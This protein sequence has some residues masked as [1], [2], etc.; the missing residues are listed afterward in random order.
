MKKCLLILLTAAIFIL[1]FISTAAAI[2]VKPITREEFEQYVKKPSPLQVTRDDP[3]IKAQV[4]D[5]PAPDFSNPSLTFTI[6]AQKVRMKDPEGNLLS[7]QVIPLDNTTAAVHD[8]VALLIETKEDW[9]TGLPQNGSI[10]LTAGCYTLSGGVD[11]SAG[12]RVLVVETD[13]TMN[14]F[15]SGGV[16]NGVLAVGDDSLEVCTCIAALK[17]LETKK[18]YDVDKTIDLGA[19]GHITLHGTVYLDY[20]FDAG[21]TGYGPYLFINKFSLEP[22]MDHIEVDLKKEFHVVDTPIIKF[23]IPIIDGVFGIDISPCFFIDVGVEGDVS[24][25]LKAGTGFSAKFRVIFGVLDI[26]DVDGYV[27]DPDASLIACNIGGEVYAGLEFGPSLSILSGVIQVGVTCRVGPVVEGFFMKTPFYPD[28]LNLYRYHA[29]RSL[30]CAQGDVHLRVGPASVI[31]RVVGSETTLYNIMNPIDYDPFA[32][33][34]YSHTYGEGSVEHQCPHH[35]YLV[36]TYVVDQNGGILPDALAGYQPYEDRFVDVADKVKKGEKGYWSLYVPKSYPAGDCKDSNTV[37]VAAFDKDPLDPSSYLMGAAV[38]TEKGQKDKDSAPDPESVTITIDESIVTIRFLD[39]GSGA[40]NL[41]APVQFHPFIS[42]VHLPDT[43]P[44]K[45]GNAFVGWNTK[46]DGSGQWYRPGAYV[47]TDTDLDLYAQFKILSN[48]YVVVYNANGGVSAPE[49]QMGTIGIPITL[50]KDGAVGKDGT[51]FLGWSLTPDGVDEYKPGDTFTCPAGETVVV[52]Y[53]VWTYEPL[54]VVKIHYDLNGGVIEKAIPDRWVRKHASFQ[55]TEDTPEKLGSVFLGWA[56][57]KD[58][59]EADY[60]PGHSYHFS[61]DTVLYAVYQPESQQSVTVTFDLNGGPTQDIPAPM[62]VRRARWIQI[63]DVRLSWD[64]FHR[65]EGWSTDPSAKKA[66]YFPGRPANF[67]ADTTLYAVWIPYYTITFDPNGGEINGSSGE[68][69]MLVRRGTVI[70]IPKAPLRY[71]YQFLYWR[72]S[73]YN[74]GDRYAVWGDHTFTAEWQ[75]KP[76]KTGD[77]APL[78][79]W[80][81]LLLLGLLGVGS[82]AASRRFRKRD[83]F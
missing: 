71:G 62:T 9:I 75:K 56:L 30:D 77:D 14:A 25:S 38:I 19:M 64:Q 72:G 3:Q 40:T 74:P 70:T 67:M 53:A 24:F 26:S 41:P 66:D 1:L 17:S 65:F 58:A 5:P 45:G 80:S 10:P 59:A 13:G 15:V 50:T 43:I 73:Q 82:L 79:L 49:P 32:E 34:Y 31:D 78:L 54:K 36:K 22:D 18:G 21:W 8:D 76:P 81:G 29:C 48:Q 47:E 37:T 4:G 68:T 39:P 44:V 42:G 12:H 61:Q 63:P 52:L 60:I 6:P 23:E 55:I 35:G 57:E 69:T 46:P 27:D 33:F 2:D 83:S 16:S 51:S 7:E 11:L 28:D 20:D